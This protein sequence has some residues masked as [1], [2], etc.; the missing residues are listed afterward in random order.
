LYKGIRPDKGSVIQL[1][2]DLR[3]K[4]KGVVHDVR[5]LVEALESASRAVEA[6]TVLATYERL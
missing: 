2:I 5:L 3:E 1:S 4:S 6:M